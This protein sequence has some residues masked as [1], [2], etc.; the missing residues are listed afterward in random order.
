MSGLNVARERYG[1]NKVIFTI[2]KQESIQVFFSSKVED[3]VRFDDL[4][5]VYVQD[6]KCEYV[7]FSHD[8]AMQFVCGLDVALAKALSGERVLDISLQ[9]N[10]GYLWNIYLNKS[11]VTSTGCEIDDWIGYKYLVWGTPSLDVWL[12]EKEGK[13]FFEVTPVYMWHFRDPEPEEKEEYV[14][15]KQFMKSYKSF[16]VTELSR[17]TICEWLEQ[18]KYLLALIECN[19]DKYLVRD[20]DMIKKYKAFMEVKKDE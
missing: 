11:A 5:A 18:T 17:E 15:Y 2:N 3:L 20:E 10:I 13:F 6:S 16:V 4:V 1:K 7:I 8:V 9:D 14:T 12:Y 19:D